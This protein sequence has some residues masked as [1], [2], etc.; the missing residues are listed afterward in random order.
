[1][2]LRKNTIYLFLLFFTALSMSGAVR[3]FTS[4]RI[5]GVVPDS[6]TGEP[7]EYATVFLIGTGRGELTDEKG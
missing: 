5:H 1:M 2:N 3:P 7:V 4:T 6:G